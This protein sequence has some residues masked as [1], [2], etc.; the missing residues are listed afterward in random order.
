MQQSEGAF[1]AK[2]HQEFK[3]LFPEGVLARQV[4]TL[5]SAGYPDVLYVRKGV[6]AWVEGKYGTGKGQRRH[7]GGGGGLSFTAP[8]RKRFTDL[9][10]AGARVLVPHLTCRQGPVDLYLYTALPELLVS[11]P[12]ECW[13]TPVFWNYVF[14]DLPPA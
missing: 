6:Y 12:Y 7:G 1:K 3:T 11:L 8:Q 10:R 9:H 5:Y 14:N 2:L 13:K 4:A